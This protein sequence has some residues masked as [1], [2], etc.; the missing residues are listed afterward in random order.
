MFDLN[1]HIAKWRHKQGQSE[2]LATR[3]L[4]ELEGHLREEIEQLVASKLSQEEAFLVARHRLGDA[5]SLAEEF[6]K[7]NAS[8]LW[9]K[10]LFW[11]AAGVLGYL[12]VMQFAGAVSKG[13][14]F[15]AGITGLRGYGLGF[16]SLV[17]GVF[18]VV[19]TLLFLYRLFRHGSAAPGLGQLL[20]TT[21]RRFILVAGL[22][23]VVIA[24]AGAQLLF[25]IITVRTIGT[26][27]YGRMAIVSGYALFALPILLPAILIIL[28][29]K[30]RVS[31]FHQA[32]A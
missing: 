27:D 3:D 12:L 23:V 22:I 25:V 30:L 10:R 11:M 17:S 19:G 20:T 13:C 21:G 32:E 15:L 31:Q 4:D 7:I 2:T 5:D 29:M 16:V 14:V 9:R 8:V 26:E 24:L 28:L 6:A 1:E 18:V